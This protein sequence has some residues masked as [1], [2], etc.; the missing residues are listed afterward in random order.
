MS[1]R[2]RVH[3]FQRKPRASGNFSLEFIFNDVRQQLAS[4]VDF[5]I[6]YARHYS[7]GLIKRILN[8]LDASSKGGLVNHITGDIHYINF[9]LPTKRNILTILDCGPMKQGSALKR[10][11]FKWVWLKIPVLKSTFVTAISE[12]TRQDI[13]T[14][15][16]CNPGKVIVIPVAVSDMFL[17]SPKEFPTNTPVLLQIGTAYNKNLERLIRALRGLDYKLVIIGALQENQKQ[18][19]HENEIMFENKLNLDQKQIIE[20]YVNCDIVTFASTFEGF[21]M[22]IVEANCVE[23]PVIAGNN[24]SMPEVGGNAAYY[25]NA[26]SEDEIRNAIIRITED[27]TLRETLIR[28]GRINKTRFSNKVI[29]E[30]YHSLYQQIWINNRN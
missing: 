23:R 29:A 10:L 1:S 26:E 3:H 21:G 5:K 7:N 9:L 18:L 20:E 14:Y 27:R 4:K 13:L 25:V 19:L 15:T 24:S 16:K 28:N 17:P 30:M 12:A 22:P 8:I 2:I 11:I 6:I